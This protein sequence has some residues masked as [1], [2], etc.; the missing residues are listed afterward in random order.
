MGAEGRSRFADRDALCAD[1][2]FATVV[3][4]VKAVVKSIVDIVVPV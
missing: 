4:G 1:V 2:L 3:V